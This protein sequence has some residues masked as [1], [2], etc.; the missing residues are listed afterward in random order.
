[1][2][3]MGSRYILYIQQDKNGNE[4]FVHRNKDG[5]LQ[6]GSVVLVDKMELGQTALCDKR[7]LAQKQ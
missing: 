6:A 3:L 7:R 4:G 5:M 1:M 2:C